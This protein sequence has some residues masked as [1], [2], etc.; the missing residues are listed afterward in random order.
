MKEVT[1]F[2]VSSIIRASMNVDIVPLTGNPLLDRYVVVLENSEAHKQCVVGAAVRPLR[3][4]VSELTPRYK[5]KV[6]ACLLGI[7]G[8]GRLLEKPAS[9]RA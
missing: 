2:T 9:T 7:H 5:I 8:C 6:K 3:C 1:D 4:P